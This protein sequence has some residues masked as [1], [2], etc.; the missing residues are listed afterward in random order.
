MLV[1]VEQVVNLR[2]LARAAEDQVEP[3]I[4]PIDLL[5][6]LS[7][8]INFLAGDE[9]EDDP[10]FRPKG[11]PNLRILT[12]INQRTAARLQHFW[13]MFLD[14]YL[15]ALRERWQNKA[16]KGPKLRE[17]QIVIIHNEELPRNLWKLGRVQKLSARTAEVKMVP[18]GTVTQRA[19]RQQ[20]I[21][22][23]GLLS[24]NI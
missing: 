3:V 17:G 13:K 23:R 9:D 4:R 24:G 12:R 5:R 1:E 18:G 6:P 19:L 21:S 10:E 22:N 2:P 14:Q 11:E 16:G 7:R 15:L 20:P 8:D